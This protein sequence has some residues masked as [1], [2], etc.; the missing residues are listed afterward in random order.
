MFKYNFFFS[1]LYSIQ[2]KLLNNNNYDKKKNRSIPMMLNSTYMSIMQG[3]YNITYD[4]R[5]CYLVNWL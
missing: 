2:N 3:H 1:C 5:G 4:T